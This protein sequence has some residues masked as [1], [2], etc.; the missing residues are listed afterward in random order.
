MAT[1]IIRKHLREENIEVPK[2]MISRSHHFF[3]PSVKGSY[4]GMFYLFNP[5]TKG[6]PRNKN[7]TEVTSEYHRSNINNY[8]KFKKYMNDFVD[9]AAYEHTKF[10]EML[11]AK[12]IHLLDF[13]QFD[14]KKPIKEI[15]TTDQNLIKDLGTLNELYKSEVLTKEEFEKAK[16]KVLN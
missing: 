15:K 4:Y 7:L 9:V 13:S 5:E 11:R 12:S 10:E 3:A 1:A 2:I 14:I 6:G 8:P 16:K